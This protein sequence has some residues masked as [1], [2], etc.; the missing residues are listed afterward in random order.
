MSG[1]HP[2]QALVQHR[3]SRAAAVVADTVEIQ[4][5]VEARIQAARVNQVVA[6]AHRTQIADCRSYAGNR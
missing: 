5:I 6:Q 3:T 1:L 4:Q 2:V